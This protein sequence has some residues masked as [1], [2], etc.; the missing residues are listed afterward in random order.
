MSRAPLCY[1]NTCPTCGAAPGEQCRTLGTR[2]LTDTHMDRI[3]RSVGWR[4]IDGKGQ[5]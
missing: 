3:K 1:A 2:R 4:Q 5:R